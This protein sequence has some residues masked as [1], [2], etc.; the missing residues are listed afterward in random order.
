MVGY[1]SSLLKHS[2]YT[3]TQKCVM[4]LATG[5]EPATCA[6]QMRCSAVKPRQHVPW[7][8]RLPTIRISQLLCVGDM[9]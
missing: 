6:L 7:K 5:I 3:S 2:K 4:E 8:P 1:D 9:H